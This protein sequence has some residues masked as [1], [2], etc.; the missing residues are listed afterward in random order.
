MVTI[1]TNGQTVNVNP[2]IQYYF[3]ADSAI[4]T[5][6]VTIGGVNGVTFTNNYNVNNYYDCNLGITTTSLVSANASVVYVTN[7]VKLSTVNDEM[8]TFV[9][10]TTGSLVLGF[11][12]ENQLIN[13]PASILNDDLL[14][15]IDD[16]YLFS[17]GDDNLGF[18]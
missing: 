13:P 15:G 17:I 10:F 12:P 6:D 18:I 7:N 4:T 11:T 5:F 14:I 2:S 1:N 8:F 16:S 9:Y 3:V